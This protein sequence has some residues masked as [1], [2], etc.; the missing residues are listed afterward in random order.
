M[1]QTEMPTGELEQKLAESFG[2]NVA[3][4][5]HLGAPIEAFLFAEEAA[6]IANAVEKRRLEFA[7]GRNCARKALAKL[8]A[9]R[10]PILAADDRSPIWPPG[11]IGSISHTDWICGAVVARSSE[12]KGIGLDIEHAVPL[13]NEVGNLALSHAD[14]VH[15]GT[16]PKCNAAGWET[17]AFCAK[18]AFHKCQHPLT[19]R[20]IDFRNVSIC[21]SGGST[22]G[23]FRVQTDMGIGAV[24]EISGFWFADGANVYAGCT[25]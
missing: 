5:L 1:H 2:A 22:R 3:V 20:V 19:Q 12:L 15:F 16:L 21:F 24:P 6:F 14:R 7:T 13:P 17:L 4:S 9:P 8:G 11:F 10:T 25:C 23:T 18:E